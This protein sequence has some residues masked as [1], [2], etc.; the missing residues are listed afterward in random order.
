M[1]LHKTSDKNGFTLIETLTV[2]SL[3]LIIAGFGITLS[4]SDF[5]RTNVQEEQS[6]IATLLTHARSQSMHNQCFGTHCSQGKPHGIYVG[7]HSYTLF[8]GSTYAQRDGEFDE[9]TT[10]KSPITVTG[11][12]EIVF[13]QLSGNTITVGEIQLHTEQGNVYRISVNAEGMINTDRY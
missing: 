2:I 12:Q 7:T 13:D 4:H 11:L 6:S 8:Q 1:A 5:I 10:H 9:I 3:F